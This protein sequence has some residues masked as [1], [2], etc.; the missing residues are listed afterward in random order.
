MRRHSQRQRK[1]PALAIESMEP[2]LACAAGISL[3]LARDTGQRGNDRITSDATLAISRSL[4]AGQQLQYRINGGVFRT[5]VMNEARQFVPEGIGADGSYRVVARVVN[6]TGRT[7]PLGTALRF[8]LDRSAAPLQV[9]LKQ[10]TGVSATDRISTNG[11]LV[12]SRQERNATVQYSRDNGSWNAATAVWGG[13][14][15]QSGLNHWRV[16]QL[17]VAGN[18]SAPVAI[19]FELDMDRDERVVRVEGPSSGAFTAVAGQQ[20]EWVLEF[21]KPMYVTATNGKVPGIQFTFRGD[22]LMARSSGGSGTNR[23]TY[24]YVFTAAQAGTGSLTAPEHACLCYGG[25]MTDA[26]GN[27]LRKHGLP[28]VT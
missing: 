16:R 17:D 26:A 4:A 28:A 6:S 21:E 13:Y 11:G 14:A 10:D 24:A 18:A 2:R 27:K 3:A 12:V 9:I 8:Q 22:T 5:A 7:T 15:P 20:I 23:L 19:E 25:G 1:P